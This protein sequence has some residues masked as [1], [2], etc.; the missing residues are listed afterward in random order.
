MKTKRYVV[1]PGLLV[2]GIL[3]GAVI[4]NGGGREPQHE[5]SDN[6]I[7]TC[8]MHPQIR[9]A[10]PGK[11]PICAMELIP[12]KSPAGTTQAVDPDAVQLSEEA[13]ALANV[14]TA[15]VSRG[16][17]VKELRLYGT[18]RPDERRLRSLT[19]H[20]GGRIER[21]L[22]GTVGESVREGQPIVSLYSPELLAAQ[23][24]LLEAGKLEGSQPALL[25][26]AREKLRLWK[27]SDSQ[28]EAIERSGSPAPTVDIR[29][30]ASGIVVAKRV[31]QGDYVGQGGA[32]FDLADLS[33]VWA[34]FEA[35]EPDLSCLKVGDRVEYTLRSLPGRTFSGR[36]S[37]IDP[38]LDPVSRTAKVR[39]ETPNPHGDL[40][41]GMYAVAVVRAGL[42]HSGDEIVIPRS[43][44][45]WT[46]RRSVVY[47]RQPDVGVPTFR[48][49]EVELGPSLGEE[50]VVLSGVAEGERIVSSGA[51]AVDASAQLEGKPSMMNRPAATPEAVASE[52]AVPEVASEVVS[53]VGHGH[54][55]LTVQGLCDM[56]K[57]RIERA[58]TSVAGVSSAMWDRND[59]QLHL[60]FDPARTSPAAVGRAVAAAGHDTDK[61]RAD[62][63]V[64][65]ALP[66]CCKYRK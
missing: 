13:V 39:V 20:V 61:Y 59:R 52:A 62:D 45:L 12:L 33:S 66:A 17:P 8:S 25:A 14:Q 16:K 49:R 56:C 6:E 58:A 18:I 55:I 37:F 19:A 22:V 48:L 10:G 63:R 41:P 54:A 3:L 46:G 40:K 34:L 35:Y 15:V 31:E 64:Y 5:H 44:V 50:Y 2:A 53:T 60:D 27:L 11:C 23:Q 38:M 9:Q 30:G 43:A 4:F 32:L 36:I 47:I 24:E 51:F 21:L 57:V 1:Y 29:A 28:I 65:D 42:K 7:W 26:A